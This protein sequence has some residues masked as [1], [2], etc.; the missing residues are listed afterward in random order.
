M[1]L[2]CRKGEIMEYQWMILKCSECKNYYAIPLDMF[3]RLYKGSESK[4][5]CPNC[6]H[7]I[8]LYGARCGVMNSDKGVKTNIIYTLIEDGIIDSDIKKYQE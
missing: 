8:Q 1:N 3:T 4:S 7:E 2:L 6:N 5:T